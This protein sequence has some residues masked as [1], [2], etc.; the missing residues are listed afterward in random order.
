[1]RESKF[2][3][4][5]TALGPTQDQTSA[6]ISIRRVARLSRNVGQPDHILAN[7]VISHKAERR[8]GSGEIWFA[9]TKHDGM[10]VDSILI[11]QA[12][13]GEA[14]SQ[15]RA[16][17]FDLPVALGLQLADRAL[18]IILNKPRVGADRLQR[19]RDDPFRLVPPRRREGAFLWT[20]FRMIVVPVTHDLINLATVHTA[21]LPLSLLDEVA[22]ERGAWR[23]R[24]MIDVAVQGLVHSEHELG[25]THFLSLRGT[26]TRFWL[27][28]AIGCKLTHSR[29]LPRIHGSKR[30]YLAR[31]KRFELL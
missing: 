22:E 8:P 19:A 4:F 2:W 28:C 11:D 23:K 16:G 17:N 7:P 5:S 1:M 31:P 27:H 3:L 18:K 14:M 20:P 6:A 15:V 29:R 9:V 26:S 12:K 10:Q 13:F 24:H 21:R 25:H 30:R